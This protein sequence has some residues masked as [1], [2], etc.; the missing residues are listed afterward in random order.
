[1]KKNIFMLVALS[2]ALACEQLSVIVVDTKK[3]ENS[4]EISSTTIDKTKIENSVV[5]NGFISSL[6]DTNP[7]IDITDTSKNSQ[8]AGEIT[9]GKISINKAPFYQNNFMIDGVSNNSLL[10]PVLNNFDDRYDTAGNEDEIFLDLDLID[11]I[12]VYTTNISAEYGNFTGGVIDAKTIR[13]KGEV[14]AKVSWNHTSDKLLK[15]HVHDLK[16]FEKAEND[17]NQPRFEKNFYNMYLSVPIDE[18]NGIVASISQKKSIIPGAYFGGFKDKK[19]ENRS[20]FLKGSHYFDDD[21]VLDVVGTYSP[22]TST[23]FKE[24]VKD[25][26]TK[27]KGG[28]YS[29][30]ANYEKDF[31]NWSLNT[32]IA[33]KSSQNTK[34]SL[35]YNK[36]WLKSN[37]KPWGPINEGE[38]EQNSQEG[39]TG[40]IK[41]EQQGISYNLKA[42][43][44][45]FN[46]WDISHDVKFGASLDFTKGTYDRKEN[47]Y[48]YIEPKWSIPTGVGVGYGVNCMGNTE[49]CVDSEQYFTERRVYQKDRVEASILATGL[50]LE[51]RIEYGRFELTPGIRFD[52]NNYL[53]NFDPSY[54]LNG[55]VKFFKENKTVIYGGLNRYYGKSFLGYKL[56]EARLPYYDQYRSTSKGNINPWG[57]SADKDIDKHIF[58]NLKT[59]YSDERNIGI[60]QD[61]DLIKIRVNVK[62]THREGKDMFSRHY[63]QYRV[64]TMPDGKTKGYY[65]PLF[66]GNAGYSKSEL[67]SLDIGPTVPIELGFA[68]LGYSFSTSWSHFSSNTDNY[69]SLIDDEEDEKINIVYYD[70]K[71][72]DKNDLPRETNPKNYNLH[73]NLAFMP[74][75]I[76]N[77]PTK[78]ALNN[79]I[80]FNSSYYDIVSVDDSEKK[81]YK[82]TLPNGV[83]KKYKVNIYEKVNFKRSVTMDLR[84]NFDFQIYGK[85]RLNMSVEATNVFDKVQNVDTSRT[86]FKTGRQIWLRLAYKY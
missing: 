70:N 76:F 30:K 39:G 20:F 65:K 64:F 26:D 83:E 12:K 45:K 34:E 55:S 19:R 46:T 22:Y 37:S 32:N 40:N 73:L 79:I 66:Y 85:N 29:L 84:A 86:K 15:V 33:Y 71:F 38:G 62:Y 27:I 11:F 59:P 63:G 57:S 44:S 25:S 68:D 23:H 47:T 42:Q 81:I 31:E 72:Y 1:M 67:V 24:Y 36:N 6:L 50:Y 14:S 8:T 16:K 28:G 58:S 21:S 56:R 75:K 35:N 77:I 4:T 51:N 80:R 9:P 82:E 53:K 10:D 17:N 61:I 43:V 60:R 3:G 2:S 48:Y 41:K 5:G 13:A 69:D 52:Y 54:R 74:F 49:G 7:E 78:V 18:K